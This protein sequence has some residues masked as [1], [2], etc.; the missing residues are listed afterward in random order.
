MIVELVQSHL[1]RSKSTVLFLFGV[2]LIA[3][4]AG[5][6][7]AQDEGICNRTKQV[8]D[9][10]LKLI[11]K[12]DCLDVKIADLANIT[13]L[14]LR[15]RNIRNLL[16]GDF[17]GLTSLQT[18]WLDQN[19][20]D[21]LPDGVFSELSFL[22]TLDLSS[23]SLENL[24]EGAFDGLTSL[25]KLRL[26]SNSIGML[27]ANSFAGLSSL[28]RLDLANNTV[29][30]L[31]DRVFAGLTSLD[32]LDLSSDSIPE[33]VVSLE[34]TGEGQFRASVKTAAPFELVLPILV[35]GGEIEGGASAITVPTGTALGET[36]T[37]T[38]DTNNA[39]A[40][41]VDLQSLP[42]LPPKHA[43]YKL[44]KGKNLPL[45]LFNA[46]PTVERVIPDQELQVGGDTIEV[47]L[48]GTFSDADGDALTFGAN[49]SDDDVAT[50]NV[51]RSTLTLN[52]QGLGLATISVTATDADGSGQEVVQT[53]QVTVKLVDEDFTV[54]PDSND[55]WTVAVAGPAGPVRITLTMGQGLRV[56]DSD[57][58]GDVDA[59]DIRG[60]VTPVSDPPPPPAGFE[61]D[62]QSAVDI[63]FSNS[64]SGTTT[65]CLSTTR[66]S[67]STLLVCRYNPVTG[68]WEWL[69][70]DVEDE[71]ETTVVCAE[72]TRFSV[73][74]VL[75]GSGRDV[76]L[77]DVNED[78]V[79]DTDDALVMYYAYQLRSLLGDG[80]TGGTARF[81]RTLLGGRAAQLSPSDTDLKKMLDRAKQW[82]NSG[83][84]VGGDI[85]ADGAINGDDALVMYYAYQFEN[86]LGNGE[87]G[88]TARFRQTLLTGRAGKPNPSD[89]DLR[90]ML[91]RANSLRD[92][93]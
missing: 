63:T 22:E 73:F 10:I 43:G 15:D 12:R 62:R 54:S 24:P 89:A 17:A 42:K 69:P 9:E 87:A 45:N 91:R 19:K 16:E 60:V 33:V 90:Q 92:A 57:N 51:N 31:P 21:D 41:S 88:G 37:V 7:Q 68:R 13:S 46:L 34:S 59:D 93:L 49:S 28:A 2:F 8:Q 64:P 39:G 35:S 78:E 55:N 18:L 40:V 80:T 26:N 81:R 23:N 74:A 3:F 75:D 83:I 86:L 27:S 25:T 77:A 1:V 52:P 65:V 56:L 58:D 72:A 85:N 36:I 29:S 67:S 61:I 20:L 30:S 70:S 50:V 32:E 71:G 4:T 6:A 66:P 14:T 11:N 5:S 76:S 48:S 84:S 53:F 38:R 79:I 82:K 47:Q 44:T